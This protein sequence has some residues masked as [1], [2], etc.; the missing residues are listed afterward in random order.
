MKSHNDDN[1][2]N[3]SGYENSYVPHCVY[4]PDKELDGLTNNYVQLTTID[5]TQ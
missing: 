5:N 2:M 3:S 4:V 1:D